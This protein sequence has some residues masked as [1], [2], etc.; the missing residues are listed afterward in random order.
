MSALNQPGCIDT[1]YGR[2]LQSVS[3]TACY[4]AVVLWATPLAAADLNKPTQIQVEAGTVSF[5][6]TTNISAVTVHGKSAALKAQVRLRQAD[7]ELV[8][9][10]VSAW[11]PVSTLSTGMGLRDEHMRKYIFTSGDGQVPDVRFRGANLTCRVAKGKENQCPVTGTLTIRG[12]ERPFQTTLKVRRE[13]GATAAYRAAADAMVKLSD[14]GIE[15]PSQFGVKAA[16]EVKFHLEFVAKE[17][18]QAA[19]LEV[20]R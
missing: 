5:D 12:V 8:L 13:G 16:D 19:A 17:A 14:Y 1:N 2:T 6:A 11:L 10:D 7:E 15:R 20:P 18:T 3:L 4:L 9:E